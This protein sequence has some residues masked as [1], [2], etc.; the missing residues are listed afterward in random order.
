MK[1]FKVVQLCIIAM[2]F[3]VTSCKHKSITEPDEETYDPRNISRTETDSYG[4]NIAIG[5]D[6]TVYIGWMDGGYGE[7]EKSSIY[8]REISPDGEMSDIEILS[9]TANDAWGPIIKIDDDCNIHVL[10]REYREDQ[11]SI[12]VY[13]MKRSTGDW[14]E[15]EVISDPSDIADINT[16]AYDPRGYIHVVYLGNNGLYYLYKPI[17]GSWSDPEVVFYTAP[18][19]MRLLVEPEGGLYLVYDD[20]SE[21][22][23]FH[24]DVSSDE[25]EGPLRV[26]DVEGANYSWLH[27]AAFD[28]S[29]RLYVVWTEWDT[30]MMYRVKEDTVWSDAYVIPLNAEKRRPRHK[31]LF[32]YNGVKYLIW[33]DFEG[34]IY[35]GYTAGELRNGMEVITAVDPPYGPLLDAEL[36][37]GIIYVVWTPEIDG[38]FEVYFD[39]IY[40]NELK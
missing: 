29:G 10:W 33:Q 12:L 36:I 28:E 13:K 5:S 20:I 19:N 37:N 24:K 15:N 26:T 40:L 39:K 23:Y 2:L 32:V 22:R 31:W 16:M 9:D 11:P 17:Y 8:W 3:F 4:P 6:G 34:D 7:L 14:C 25:W 35:L 21:V 27:C 38:H 18:S 30:L 1:Y